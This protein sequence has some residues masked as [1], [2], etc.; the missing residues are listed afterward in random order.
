[1]KPGVFDPWRQER[2]ELEETPQSPPLEADEIQRFCVRFEGRRYGINV[3]LSKHVD[4]DLPETPESNEA[5]LK[6]II[7]AVYEISKK[8]SETLVGSVISVGDMPE[9]EYTVTLRDGSRS[10]TIVSPSAGGLKLVQAVDTMAAWFRALINR[11]D[12]VSRVFSTRN[13]RPFAR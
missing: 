8:Y 9:T 1:M 11:H 13:I 10:V 6:I 2:P 4:D 3:W 5:A 7:D 12:D